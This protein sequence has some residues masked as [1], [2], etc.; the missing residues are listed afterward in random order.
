MANHRTH[1]PRV[2]RLPFESRDPTPSPPLADSSHLSA[3]W[4]SAVGQ[5]GQRVQ[6][7]RR[8]CRAKH[9]SVP[10]S[11]AMGLLGLSGRERRNFTRIHASNLQN[12]LLYFSTSS[13]IS[14]TCEFNPKTRWLGF[15]IQT[16]IL[17]IRRFYPVRRLKN[18]NGLD[19]FGINHFILLT[20]QP[21]KHANRS[22]QQA[23]LEDL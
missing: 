1:S 4:V 19:M 16:A 21:E 12:H 20:V 15:S 11:S 2:S 10:T 17:G 9:L 6:E 8:C 22:R 18:T 3:R 5:R 13:F 14:E 7:V 23:L